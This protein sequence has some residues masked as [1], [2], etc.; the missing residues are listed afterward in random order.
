MLRFRETHQTQSTHHTHGTHF[1]EEGSPE[2]WPPAPLLQCTPTWVL[3]QRPTHEFWNK[4]S[5]TAGR[6][7][8]VAFLIQTN[9]EAESTV[10]QV[11]YSASTQDDNWGSLYGGTYVLQIEKLARILNQLNL[12]PA[13][14]I[15]CWWS[16]DLLPPYYTVLCS[17][18]LLAVFNL[19]LVSLES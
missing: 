17:R 5:S 16:E 10:V 19:H 13:S 15:A 9:A 18:L 4:T 7:S 6:V 14:V 3:W 11:Q 2:V 12:C 1:R 8:Q